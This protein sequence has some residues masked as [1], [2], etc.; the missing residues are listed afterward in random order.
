MAELA[1]IELDGET[2]KQAAGGGCYT[3]YSPE[4]GEYGK[5]PHKLKC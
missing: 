4:K 3:D 5:E 1:D 2:L